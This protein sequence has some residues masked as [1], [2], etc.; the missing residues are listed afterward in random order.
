MEYA[1]RNNA[2]LASLLPEM[3]CET[4]WESVV[5]PLA[6]IVLMQSFPLFWVNDDRKK[7]AFANG[8]YIL[9]RRTAYDAAG[10]HERCATGSSRTSAWPAR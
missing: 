5:Q 3:R 2:A 4:F 6:G 1:R 8:Q 10:G 9:I 7:L